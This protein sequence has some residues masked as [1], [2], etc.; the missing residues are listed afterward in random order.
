M[1][2][3]SIGDKKIQRVTLIPLGMTKKGQ[4]EPLKESDPR[5]EEVLRYMRWLCD[6]QRLNT[7]FVREGDEIR[8]ITE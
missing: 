7:Q 4:P 2:K 5:N 8:V 1:V 6:D 3:C